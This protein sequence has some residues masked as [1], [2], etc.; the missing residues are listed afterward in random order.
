[1]GPKELKKAIGVVD[2]CLAKNLSGINYRRG[3]F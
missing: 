2:S 1:M 3:S